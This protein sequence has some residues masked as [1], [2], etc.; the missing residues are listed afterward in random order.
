MKAH[1]N[2][3]IAWQVHSQQQAHHHVLIVLLVRT[4]WMDL[5]R[6]PHV[7]PGRIQVLM[8]LEHA[9]FAQQVYILWK[10]RLRAAF[11]KQVSF[12]LPTLAFVLAVQQENFRQKDHQIVQIVILVRILWKVA[13]AVQIVKQESIH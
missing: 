3:L 7:Q 4:L 10:A 2:V 1:L 13:Q 6:V 11:A 8:D 5:A 12:Q 9:Q